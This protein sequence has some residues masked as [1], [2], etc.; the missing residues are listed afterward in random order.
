VCTYVNITSLFDFCGNC[1]GDN[2]ECFFSSALGT[3]AVVGISAGV[4]VAIA[5]AA[6]IACLIAFFAT[7]KGYAYY[8]AKSDAAAASMQ[9]NPYFKN[10]TLQGEMM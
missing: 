4:A 9:T 2:T 7:R 8:K 1:Q 6:V 10:N 3:E 5:V